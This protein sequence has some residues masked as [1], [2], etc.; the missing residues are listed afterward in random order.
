MRREREDVRCQN[1]AVAVEKFG[2]IDITLHSK[3]V[4]ET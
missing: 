1:D 2:V 4:E 3:Q